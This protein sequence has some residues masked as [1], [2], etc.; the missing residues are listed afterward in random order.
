MLRAY[1]FCAGPATMPLPV[2]EEAQAELVDF[3]GSGMSILES[4]HRGREYSAVHEEATAN[5]KELGILRGFA[6]FYPA[7][8]AFS[9][10]FGYQWKLR[11]L[12]ADR[13]LNQAIPVAKPR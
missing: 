9:S 13:P 1:N 4:S 3:K 10:G 12:H 6:T 8:K 11:V 7:T 5:F 2:L